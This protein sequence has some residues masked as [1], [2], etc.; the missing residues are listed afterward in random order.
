MDEYCKVVTD[1]IELYTRFA[2]IPR[3]GEY[4]D[5]NGDI[6]KVEK[7]THVFVT[8]SASDIVITVTLTEQQD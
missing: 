3:S 6:Y 2:S 7:V 5:I 1:E 8:G 4:I